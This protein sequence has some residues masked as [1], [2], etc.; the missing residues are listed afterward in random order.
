VIHPG[1]GLRRGAAM[2]AFLLLCPACSVVGRRT[3]KAAG[4][5]I[6]VGLPGIGSLDPAE[7]TTLA[8]LTILRTACDSLVGQDPSTGDLKPALAASWTFAPGAKA[9]TVRLKPEARYHDG[10]R[11]LPAQVAE[12]LS[13]VAQTGGASPAARE[14][15][16]VLGH[17]GEQGAGSIR[18]T[19]DG[20]LRIDLPQA[21]AG[22][23]V[24]LANP[25]LAPVGPAP[26]GDEAA[27]PACAG[28]YRI[29]RTR[30]GL[31]L[32]RDAGYTTGNAAFRARGMGYA[33]T[34]SV[35]EYGSA[36]E[37]YEALEAGTVDAAPV[38]ESRVAQAEA[39]GAGHARRGTS[40][41]TYLAF[42]TKQV[43]TSN[44]IFRR[45]VSMALDRV[46]LIDAAFGDRRP[47]A[48]RWL[49]EAPDRP[50][51]R[52]CEAGARRVAD[53]DPAR[54]MLATAGI[55]PATVRLP[56]LFDQAETS[57]QVVQAIEAQL[58]ENL[59]I[60][61][62]PEPLDVTDFEAAVA[63]RPG[64]KAWIAMTPGDFG[65]PEH[66]LEALFR[67]GSHDNA[68]QFS[69]A[70]IDDLIDR[71]RS[72]ADTGDRDR[73]YADVEARACELMPDVPLWTGVSH[74]AFDPRKLAFTGPSPI[75]PFGGLLLREARLR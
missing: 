22:L 58:E 1:N 28:P 43:P 6:T 29:E 15:T 50:T 57:A 64:P 37:A 46:A 75:D 59:G 65:V 17:P 26:D 70:R 61:V 44:P 35:K 40:E 34:I 20:E 68:N 62:R 48:I 67:T 11:V 72:A 31:E 14:L 52:S 27:G 21:F 32:V 51:P 49:V 63:A 7:A 55:D 71:G 25:A 23:P 69:D 8:A 66:V 16:G 10:S 9:L 45:A 56:L 4:G 42:D 73:A 47:P 18:V 24:L 3:Q 5:T 36:E 33:R 19:E 74:W 54:E 38:P 30:A 60:S 2:V 13:G 12:Q 53:R 39:R 41:I